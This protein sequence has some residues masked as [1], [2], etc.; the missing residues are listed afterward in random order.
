MRREGIDTQHEVA[1]PRA[2]SDQVRGIQ[3]HAS[4][5]AP[6][7]QPGM[8]TIGACH[9]PALL[10]GRPISRG[11][12]LTTLVLLAVGLL[13]A[14]VH[15]SS[16]LEVVPQ[17]APP[18]ELRDGGAAESNGPELEQRIQ[19]LKNETLAFAG[20]S[21]AL[22]RGYF[23]EEG[24][25]I[26][27]LPPPAGGADL[28]AL[29]SGDADVAVTPWSPGLFTADTG[30]PGLRIVAA[31]TVQAPGRSE[32]LLASKRLMDSQPLVGYP[33][34]TGKRI[35]L[36]PHPGIAALMMERAL[37]S[38]GVDSHAV[39]YVDLGPSEVAAALERGIVDVAYAPEPYAS[40]AVAQ[41]LAV[42]WRELGDLLPDHPA[43]LWV[44][45]DAFVSHQPDAARRF[46][47]AVMRGVR[48]YDLALTRNIG[49][50][51]VVATLERM[52]TTTPKPHYDSIA[53]IKLPPDGNIP[54][55]QL[56]DDIQWLV[57]IKELSTPP[58]LAAL[59]DTRFIDY[60]NARL[61][62]P[63]P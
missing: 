42:R 18:S 56:R 19:V 55:L 6:T 30:S 44:Y 2:I 35:G 62:A 46:M 61:G 59:V 47:T 22:A 4:P 60:A 17:P 39:Q 40:E 21:I 3:T 33:D 51:D 48:D 14:G 54:L 7:G 8:S 5:H 57:N 15:C 11:S 36:P 32:A 10:P 58:D 34:L 53:P 1:P 52:S 45:S 25:I 13:V 12:S 63:A 29:R 43:A 28:A 31:A 41:G 23:D 16:P 49:K 27:L 37:V 38:A 9:Q 20:V 24:L 50:R 26:D